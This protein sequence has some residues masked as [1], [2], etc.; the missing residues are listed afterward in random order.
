MKRDGKQTLLIIKPDAVGRCLIGAVLSRI[1]DGGF[2][3]R[4]L[5]MLKLATQQARAFYAVHEGKPFLDSL[6]EYMTSG[7]SVV[8]VVER[9]DAVNEL[10]RLVG[11][12]D[13]AQ[14]SAGSIRADF[15]L[16]VQKN[17]VHAS[18][19]DENA[20]KEIQFFFRGDCDV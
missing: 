8:A 11:A 14:A 5:Q 9:D 18:D 15:G 2:V 3:V 17:A 13:P 4:R 16:D 1:E 19:S 12:T 10:R 7:P 6:V 20:D